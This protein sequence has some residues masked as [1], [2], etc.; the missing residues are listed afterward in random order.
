MDRPLIIFPQAIVADR[1]TRQFPPTRPSFPTKE[2][3]IERLEPKMQ[4]IEQAFNNQRISVQSDMTGTL[5]EQTLV[6]ET[7]D[8]V[9]NFT[10]AVK[11][12]KGL[13]WLVEWEEKFDSDDDFHYK[14]KKTDEKSDKQIDGRLFLIM[15]D[16]R[17]MTELQSMWHKFKNNIDFDLGMAPIKHLFT[18]LKDIRLW[19][20]NDRFVGT[21]FEEEW[22]ERVNAGHEV[23]RFEI[24]LWYRS[25]PE[26]RR[27]ASKN[28]RSLVQKDNGS[29]INETIIESIQYHALLVEAPI[30]IFNNLNE[31]THVQLIRS[32]HIMFFRPIGQAMVSIPEDDS[33]VENTNNIPEVI[34]SSLQ[35]VAALF[36]GIP[37]Q[38]HSL[39]KGRLVVDDPDNF[40]QNYQMHERV[41]GT[42]MASLI[43]HG[44]LDEKNV[45]L[46]RPLYVRPIMQPDY[47]DWINDSRVECIPDNILPIDLVHRAV[48]RMFEGENGSKPTAPS[49][50]I[51]NL[52]IG[53]FAR[54]FNFTLSPWAKLLDWLS[55]KYRVLFIVSAGN[56]VDGIIIN[57]KNTV[58][59][60][61]LTPQ[62]ISSK[63]LKEMLE[64]AN[65]RRI[66]SPAEAMNV[67]T[68]GALHD[69]AS[70]SNYVLGNRH[71]IM[72]YM[73]MVSP[74]SRFGLGY[75]RSVKPD[76][77]FY[78]GRQLYMRDVY[79]RYDFTINKSLR[80]P[81]QKVAYPANQGSIDSVAYT[82]GTSNATALATRTAIM[83][84]ENLMELRQD[85]PGSELFQDGL[86]SV[87]IKTLLV[88]GASWGSIKPMLEENL[89]KKKDYF[90]DRVA[91]RFI[92]Y[93]SVD[94]SRIFNCTAQRVT[95]L[96]CGELTRDKKHIYR[97]PLPP[98]LSSKTVWRRL[99]ITLGWFTPINCSD[100]KYRRAH[101]SFAPPTKEL[102]VKRMDV[103]D[104]AVKRGTVQH[105]ILE[106]EQAAAFVDGTNL[107]I[108]VNCREDAGGLTGTVPYGL[109]LSL[110]VKEGVN[111]EVYQ[112][113]RNRIRPRIRP[114]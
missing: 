47:R 108:E 9:Q 91:P 110:E 70:G 82:R 31:N 30:S 107:V 19:N 100:Q 113:V 96:G 25:N 104:D 81:G 95:L 38:N 53:D 88:H 78:G 37:L 46:S 1:E 17:A 54:P 13:E 56:Y 21:G 103:D 62:Q 63:V 33:D 28:I 51:I 84:Y 6:I 27:H 5:P 57:E 45:P 112:E 86:M 98:S 64:N 8:T 89:K 3:Q 72:A 20:I 23:I 43:L 16:Q 105:E 75:R 79:N 87:L 18:Q 11:K 76:V 41:H 32:E 29:I 97:V 111:V 22:Q 77:L 15:S 42:T 39:L 35:P 48:V 61:Q 52:S 99:T 114:Q 26:V 55:F 73:P 58:N 85:Q 49:V 92:G 4:R 44:E 7:A 59:I 71:E 36:D 10:N 102:V 90:R 68:V 80:A 2:R 50:K 106:G 60:D 109:A 12:I 93:G 69:D 14:K 65:L 74:V 101:L 34:E 67:L 83:T 40:A 94:A 24:E 66:I